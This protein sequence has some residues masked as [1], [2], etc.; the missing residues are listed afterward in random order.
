MLY[1]NKKTGRFLENTVSSLLSKSIFCFIFLVKHTSEMLCK[2]NTPIL[3][4]N[5]KTK[6]NLSCLLRRLRNRQWNYVG[7]SKKL[8][9]FLNLI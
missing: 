9:L 5:F 4:I 8:R 2:K 1:I 3:K 7:N 6:L